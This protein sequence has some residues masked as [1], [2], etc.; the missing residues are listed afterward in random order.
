MTT[1]TDWQGVALALCLLVQ[2]DARVVSISAVDTTVETTVETTVWTAYLAQQVA[3]LLQ[4][5]I[6]IFM[7][8]L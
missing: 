5:Y 3:Q 7:A 4:R 8:Q 2:Q 1:Q 6:Y